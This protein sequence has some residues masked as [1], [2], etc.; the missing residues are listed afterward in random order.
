MDFYNKIKEACA[1]K[2]MSITEL[3][4]KLGISKANIKNW[5]KGVLPKFSIRLKI[6]ELTEMPIQDILTPDE[7]ATYISVKKE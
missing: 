7:L 3:T 5:K 4:E 1:R 2:E 6:A